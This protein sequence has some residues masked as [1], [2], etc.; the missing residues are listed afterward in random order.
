[1]PAPAQLAQVVENERTEHRRCAQHTRCLDSQV[2]QFAAAALVHHCT[3]L[4]IVTKFERMLFVHADS[5]RVGGREEFHFNRAEILSEPSA[6]TFKD[7]FADGIV[8]IDIR[9][10]LRENGT[11]RNHGTGFRIQ[12]HNFPSLFGRIDRLV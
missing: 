8:T 6:I 7:G 10:H 4:D 1:M 12:E 3:A 2:A 5:R 11:P 9:M